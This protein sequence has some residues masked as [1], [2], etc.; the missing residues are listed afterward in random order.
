M[1]NI[2]EFSI[3]IV[4]FDGQDLNYLLRNF[5]R[6]FNFKKIKVYLGKIMINQNYD[7]L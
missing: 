3:V 1:T 5:G 6:K 2:L 7:T 4:E